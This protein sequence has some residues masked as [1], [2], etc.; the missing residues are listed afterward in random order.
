M[1]NS[2]TI[3]SEKLVYHQILNINNKSEDRRCRFPFIWLSWLVSIFLLF[4]LDNT[5][6]FE[7]TLRKITQLLLTFSPFSKLTEIS[8]K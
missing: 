8:V 6:K 2:G 7:I 5:W 1:E 4:D 3:L